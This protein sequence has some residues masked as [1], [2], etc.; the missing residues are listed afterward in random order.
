MLKN[1]KM[2]FEIKTKISDLI[3]F[4]KRLL[5]D[6][7]KELKFSLKQNWKLYLMAG[8]IVLLIFIPYFSN[9]GTDSD[10]PKDLSLE[11]V[12]T[13][14]GWAIG[15]ANTI[16]F[17]LDK[18][19]LFI[20]SWIAWLFSAIVGL[21]TFVNQEGVMTGWRIV[22]DICNLAFILILLAIGF[23]TILRIPTYHVKKLIVPF[24]VAVIL[25]NFSR[26]ICGVIL[27]FCNVL[28]D[29]FLE[30]IL[31]ST[32]NGSKI[33]EAFL[34]RLSLTKLL[35]LGSESKEPAVFMGLF[36]TLLF[37]IALSIAMLLIAVFLLVRYV[38]LLILIIFSPLAFLA[39]LIPGPGGSFSGK[40]WTKFLQNAF[41]GPAVAFMLFLSFL[42]M[43][44]MLGSLFTEMPSD[45]AGG[46]PQIIGT[47]FTFQH[48]VSFIV[49]ILLL[50]L[51]VNVSKNMGMAGA[52]SVMKA[53][54]SIGGYVAKSPKLLGAGAIAAGA[55]AF[56]LSGAGLVGG[57]ILG[58][59]GLG[60]LG[61]AGFR[62]ARDWVYGKTGNWGRT[63]AGAVDKEK[64]KMKDEQAPA[65]QTMSD[66]QIQSTVDNIAE[67]KMGRLKAQGINYG[68]RKGQAIMGASI[69]E[70]LKRN[71]VPKSLKIDLTDS[72]G[73][74]A[75]KLEAG[76]RYA[77]LAG[78]AGADVLA[79]NPHWGKDQASIKRKV[80]AASADEVAKFNP[81][82]WHSPEVRTSV[83]GGQ[84][85]KIGNNPD[86]ANA[87]LQHAAANMTTGTTDQKNFSQ[88]AL[89]AMMKKL[90]VKHASD[91]QYNAKD[92]RG[93]VSVSYR[94][95]AGNL[96]PKFIPHGSF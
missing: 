78:R 55:G 33:H 88:E 24:V 79:Q 11:P 20:L 27:D 9:A 59:L 26:L 95:T 71:I 69:E 35:D 25:V 1:L 5:L 29:S 82:A 56:G 3:F 58:G 23:A 16:L 7:Y 85:G 17:Y 47:E 40:W 77:A 66:K 91:P 84:G 89:N 32:G 2:P 31:E 72:A 38:T 94:D 22:K 60:R 4:L 42:I 68:T 74:K 37:L 34:N 93:G 13:I 10:P 15:V 75:S 49:V 81:D 18:L 67:G 44:S 61:S 63:R 96:V 36:L 8:V 39:Q 45:V 54:K 41:Y 12:G 57:A 48:F 46:A 6:F 76:K 90:G 14:G 51:A 64:K 50:Y 73:V 43:D 83:R 19:F 86:A 53:A 28:M 62:G 65:V 52:S 21:R 87:F 30:P 92:E 70:A 80:Q